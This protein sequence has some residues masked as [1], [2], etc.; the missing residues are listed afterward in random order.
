M[1]AILLLTML[2]VTTSVAG[3]DW[4]RY[5]PPARGNL[6]VDEVLTSGA[7][8]ATLRLPKIGRYYL[9]LLREGD[10]SRALTEPL[11]VVLELE[12]ARGKRVLLSRRFEVAFA[13]AER[14][15][16]LLWLEAPDTL[17]A[18]RNLAL[19]L[20]LHGASAAQLAATPLRLQLNRKPELVPLPVR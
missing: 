12:I 13:P 20:V 16:T 9:E 1:P 2:F 3:A 14:A 15:H 7:Q 18:R 6:I 4:Y 11:R 17:P 10:E 5:T 19:R 8:T